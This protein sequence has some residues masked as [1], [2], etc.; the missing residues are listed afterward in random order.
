MRHGQKYRKNVHFVRD[1]LT[2]CTRL[3]RNA[4]V[5]LLV[6]AEGF[7]RA[8]KNPRKKNG[9]L[10]YVG[11]YVLKALLL[12]YHGDDGLCCPSINTLAKATGLSR[13]SVVNGIARLEA[14]GVLVRTPRLVK[15]M[16]DGILCCVQ[17]TNLYGFRQQHT[18]QHTI[19]QHGRAIQ[20]YRSTPNSTPRPRVHHAASSKNKGACSISALLQ[21]EAFSYQAIA[22][23]R[24]AAGLGPV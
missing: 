1:V 17:G 7:E 14:V 6:W 2:A 21:L 5:K 22:Q 19:L 10:G 13:Q 18:Q 8:S 15:V 3:D 16:I 12:R 20:R 24:S 11:L 9:R 4:R 23:R